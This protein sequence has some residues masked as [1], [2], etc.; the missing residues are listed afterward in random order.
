[1]KDME[2]TKFEEVYNEDIIQS[3]NETLNH[4]IT[5]EEEKAFA[6]FESMH[7]EGKITDEEILK[8]LADPTNEGVVGSIFGGLA[9]FALGKKIGKIVA[10]VLG[11]EKGILYDL[12]TSRIFGA[13]MGTSIAKQF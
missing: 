6:L 5:P 1:M 12:L 2:F 8:W 13:A 4:E 11:V 7:A 10:K 3:L 9:G